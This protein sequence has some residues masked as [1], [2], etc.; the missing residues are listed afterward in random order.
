M[1][2]T[3]DAVDTVDSV[4]TIEIAL[5][6]LVFI[7]FQLFSIIITPQYLCFVKA[8]CLCRNNRPF[9]GVRVVPVP[10][11][12]QGPICYQRDVGP[13][14]IDNQVKVKSVASH[15]TLDVVVRGPGPLLAVLTIGFVQPKRSS[16]MNSLNLKTAIRVMFV[17]Q[18][19]VRL[20][21]PELMV[22]ILMF[23]LHV[24]IP[25]SCQCCQ[26]PP[27]LKRS[28]QIEPGV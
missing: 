9:L 19:T 14:D 1:V 4:Y 6:C 7:Y 20:K 21:S 24:A 23:T 25:V 15:S 5:H 22:I 26:H 18:T 3:V 17:G 16:L 10:R 12:D 11:M 28:L 13:F 2:H 27:S 8:V